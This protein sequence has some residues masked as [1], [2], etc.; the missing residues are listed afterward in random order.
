MEPRTKKM[1]NKGDSIIKQTTLILMGEYS[2][3][4]LVSVSTIYSGIPHLR[5]C[6]LRNRYTEIFEKVSIFKKMLSLKEL[7]FLI[8]S[9][10]LTPLTQ[11]RFIV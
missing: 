9:L 5:K 4:R 7:H 2:A 8:H 10:M 11:E 3:L 6:M 1:S